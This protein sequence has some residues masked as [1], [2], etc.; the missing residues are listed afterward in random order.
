MREPLIMIDFPSAPI[1]GQI[2]SASNG[3]TY[4][5]STTYSAWVAQ[6]GSGGGG[7]YPPSPTPVLGTWMQNC[8]N[9]NVFGDWIWGNYTI[10]TPIVVTL[11]NHSAGLGFDFHGALLSCGFTNTAVDMITIISP[12]TNAF[13]IYVNGFRIRNVYMNGQSACRNCLMLSA[14]LSASGQLFGGSVS[15]SIFRAAVNSGLIFY[16]GIFEEDVTD[17]MCTGNGNGGL[18][19]KNPTSGT[20]GVISSIKVYGGDYRENKYGILCSADTAFQEW[21]GLKVWGS[22]FIANLSAGIYAPPGMALIDGCHLEN[23]CVTSGGFTIGAIRTDF[24][25]TTITNCDATALSTASTQRY[26]ADIVQGSGSWSAILYS[27]AAISNLSIYEV[28]HVNAGH[29][30]ID[31][32]TYPDYNVIGVA[33]TTLHQTT[34]TTSTI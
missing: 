16:G 13:T 8:I 19:L 10:T 34:E 21:G 25:S 29:L 7:T 20:G 12:D 3:V 23:N 5:Y 27:K 6:A 9:T 31:R 4:Q 32:R 28:A 2:F 1:N 33:T 24:G 15:D 11:T 18:E 22:D 14:K 26:C 30:W 17:C